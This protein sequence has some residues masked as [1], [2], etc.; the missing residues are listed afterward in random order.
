ML[1]YV[2]DYK[3]ATAAV[4]ASGEGLG[5]FLQENME[6]DARNMIVFVGLFGV[7]Y[8][9]DNTETAKEVRVSLQS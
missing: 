1:D 2:L 4:I 5:A 8:C 7:G 3:L 9:F 6:A